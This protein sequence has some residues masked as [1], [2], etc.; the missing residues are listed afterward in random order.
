SIA[1]YVGYVKAT[2]TIM[3]SGDFDAGT[4]ALQRVVAQAEA[5]RNDQVLAQVWQWVAFADEQLGRDEEAIIWADN[6]E[7]VHQ[8]LHLSPDSQ[9]VGLRAQALSNLGRNDEALAEVRRGLA[10]LQPIADN[11][12]S[13][14]RRDQL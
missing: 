6:A 1:A 11:Q 5:A 13:A 8:R 4:R 2:Q 7:A 10:L 3:T 14:P 9:N 12:E